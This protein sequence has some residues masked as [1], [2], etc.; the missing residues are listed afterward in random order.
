MKTLI[1]LGVLFVCNVR[2]NRPTP[3]ILEKNEG[4]TRMWRPLPGDTLAPR[5]I[6][7]VDPVNGGSD[8]MALGTETFAP[9]DSIETHRHPSADEII[10]LQ[11]GM[12]RVHL[13]R[14]VRDVHPGAVVFIPINTSISFHFTGR[15]S[16]HITF[17][18]SSPGFERY[19][20]A[21]SVREGEKNVPLTK[22]ESDSLDKHFAHQ[23]IYANSAIHD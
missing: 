22:A 3:L 11:S 6:L 13:G 5:F 21:E 19:M 1:V 4:E 20:R 16:S 2:I 10:L 14:V 8:H 18:F 17:I 9:G 15:D 7:K 12:A 23:V